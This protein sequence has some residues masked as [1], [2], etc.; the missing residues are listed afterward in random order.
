MQKLIDLSNSEI[1]TVSKQIA[2]AFYDYKYNDEDRGL[3]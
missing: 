1:K 3:I 2:D